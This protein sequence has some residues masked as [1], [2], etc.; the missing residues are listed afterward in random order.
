MPRNAKNPN[1]PITRLREALSTPNSTVTRKLFCERYGFPLDSITALERGSYR[2]NRET[3]QRIASATGVSFRS[4]LLN[5][6]PL[7]AWDN[8][9]VTPAT[10][11]P[12]VP[13]RE[14]EVE[15]MRFF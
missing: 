13:L 12:S 4:L 2:L 15:K 7:R 5:Q 6:E 8:S 11:P 14:K 3:A 1:N 9:L 10:K